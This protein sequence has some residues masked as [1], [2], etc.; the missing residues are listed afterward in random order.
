MNNML[1]P[2]LTRGGLFGPVRPVSGG[3]SSYVR[4]HADRQSLFE[5]RSARRWG[6]W[7]ILGVPTAILW[8]DNPCVP[9]IED[10]DGCPEDVIFGLWP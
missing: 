5:A 4:A 1:N 2:N 7:S 8:L 3:R 9:T 10:P 6:D